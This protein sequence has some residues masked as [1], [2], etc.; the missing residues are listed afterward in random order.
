MSLL[1]VLEKT[2]RDLLDLSTRNRLIHTSIDADRSNG[3]LIPEQEP[4]S[5]FLRLVRQ[6]KTFTF[7]SV[8]ENSD[9]PATDTSDV[10]LKTLFSRNKLR[11]RLLKCFFEARTA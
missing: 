1:S 8:V 5:L 10:S 2:R 3:I 9:S 6:T 11:E 4:D 7:D